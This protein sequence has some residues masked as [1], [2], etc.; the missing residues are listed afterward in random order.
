MSYAPKQLAQSYPDQSVL[1]LRE[2]IL[3]G[4]VL[5]LESFRQIIF[6]PKLLPKEKQ[7]IIAQIFTT[8]FGSNLINFLLFLLE[9]N[10]L[11]D[12]DQILSEFKKILK[13]KNIALSGT[14]TVAQAMAET[15]KTKL[16]QDLTQQIGTPVVLEE[17]VKPALLGGAIVEV[18]GKTYNNSYQYKLS[19]L[20]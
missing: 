11:K 16:E 8:N 3:L 19:K 18:D 6:N 14:V 17:I 9:E 5:S 10:S 15:E 2:M 20:K 7:G 12:F 4:K 1:A 13:N